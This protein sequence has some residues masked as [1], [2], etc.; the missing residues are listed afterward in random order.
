MRNHFWAV[1]ATLVLVAL[2]SGARAAVQVWNVGGSGAGPYTVSY[3]LLSGNS[4]PAGVAA[5]TGMTLKVYNSGGTLVATRVISDTTKWTSGAHTGTSGVT[6]DGMDDASNN[7][8]QGT[9]YAQLEITGA[10]QAAPAMVGGVTGLAT[11]SGGNTDGRWSF[12][13]GANW[14]IT[15]QYHNTMFWPSTNSS[16]GAGKNGVYTVMPD[17]SNALIGAS[18]TYAGGSD[19]ASSGYSKAACV[20]SDGYVAV[21]DTSSNTGGKLTVLAPNASGTNTIAQNVYATYGSAL[22]TRATAAFGTKGSIDLFYLD[23]AATST[24]FLSGTKNVNYAHYGTGAISPVAIIPSTNFPSSVRSIAVNRAMNVIWV[25]GTNATGTVTTFMVKRFTRGAGAINLATSWT[26]DGA[27]SI[28]IPAPVATNNQ[29]AAWVA[30]S[31]DESILWVS[32]NSATGASQSAVFGVNP[33][34][35]VAIAGQSITGTSLPQWSEAIEPFGAYDGATYTNGNLLFATFSGTTGTSA[36]NWGIISPADTG[37]ADK[38][39]GGPFS[40]LNGS[41]QVNITSGPNVVPNYQG[42]AFSWT[43]DV[44]SDTKVEYGLTAS[45]GAS[46]SDATPNVSHAA[47][48]TG[49]LPS[50]HYFY[51][52]TSHFAAAGVT[53]AV[54]TGTFD[55]TALT[56][57]GPTTTAT[58]NGAT[59][60]WSTSNGPGG[61]AAASTT[62][63]NYGTTS[64]TYFKTVTDN[65]LVSSHSVTLP[66]IL[67][68]TSYFFTVSGG[69]GAGVTSGT[70]AE[71][72][73]AT[74][75]SISVSND[76]LTATGTSATISFNTNLPCTVAMVWGPT[77]SPTTAVTDAGDGTT[78]HSYTVTGLTPGTT[79]YYTTTTSGAGSITRGPSAVSAF[80]TSKA[81][82]PAT[83]TQTTAADVSLSSRVNLAT[84]ADGAIAS[85]AIQGVPGVPIAGTALPSARFYNSV[86]ISRGFIYVLGGRTTSAAASSIV[87]VAYNTIS[88]SGALGATWTEVAANALP[89]GIAAN[90][91]M[92]FAYNGYIYYAGG[93]NTTGASV[94]TVYYTKQNADGTL[95]LPAG[96]TAAGT[97][98]VWTAATALP[99]TRYLGSARTVDGYAMVS[100]GFTT[101]TTAG[102]ASDA[103]Y[104]ARIRP[105][106]SLGSWFVSRATDTKTYQREAVNNHK[107]YITGGQIN[108]GLTT[109]NTE[110]VVSAQPNRDLNPWVRVTSL[111]GHTTNV[112]DNP[113][114][115]G[116]AFDG[117]WSMASDLVR[118]KII[119]AAG[120]LNATTAGATQT[121]TNKISYTK[122]GADEIPGAWTDATAASATV[123]YPVAAIDL[124]AA[125]WNGNLYAAGGRTDAVSAAVANVVQ[126]PFVDEAGSPYCYSGT[127]ESN[128]ID[129]TGGA[130]VTNLKRLQVNGTGI[131]PSS[132]E[133]RYRYCDS[134]GVLTDWLTAASSDEPL[135]G[136]ARY[137]QYQLVLKGN[138]TATPTVSSV[139]VTTGASADLS[140]SNM[141]V[142]NPAPNP[143]ATVTYTIVVANNGPDAAPG[144]V[145]TDNL[146]AT[147]TFV[148]ATG[149]VVGGTGNSRTVTIDN[150]PSGGTA[151]VTVTA[152]V[153]AGTFGQTITN[154]ASESFT[155]TDA[156]A[157]N[158]TANAALTVNSAVTVNTVTFNPSAV[159]VNRTTTITATVTP[160]TNPVATVTADLSPIGGSPTQALSNGGA[161]NTY[162][163]IATVGSGVSGGSKTINVLATDA[164]DGLTGA[165]SGALTVYNATEM[166][167]T[168]EPLG[169][170]KAFPL[171]VQPV[172][173]VEA[174]NGD[175]TTNYSGPVTIALKAGTGTAGAVL[176]GTLTVNAVAG[177]ATFTDLAID[178]PGTGYVLTA[179]AADL[180]LSVDSAAFSVG[181]TPTGPWGD[182]DQDG[183]VTV[184]D[185]DLVDAYI[186][187]PGSLS[188]PQRERIVRYG[189]IAGAHNVNSVG[190]GVVDMNDLLR[191][192]RLAAGII[193]PGTA[194][195]EFPH[196]GDVDNDG[197]VTI[198]D[199]V[200][201]ARYLNGLESDAALIAR[202]QTAGVG[203]VAPT[204]QK[205]AFGDGQITA[206]D[207]LLIRQRA[208]GT[209]VNPPAYQDYW[210]MIP[211]D[212]YQFTDINRRS[213]DALNQTTFLTSAGANPLNYSF[214]PRGYTVSEVVADDGASLA[215]VYKGI[216]GSIYAL[217]AQFPYFSA[218]RMD[219]QSPMKV[220]D[221][222]QLTPGASWTG[223]IVGNMTS[224]GLH[225]V[226][227]K[228]T[229]LRV[230]DTYTNAAGAYNTP[231]TPIFSTW[232]QT[233]SIRIDIAVLASANS[234]IEMQQAVFFDFAPGIGPVRRGQAPIQGMAAPTNDRPLIELDQTTVRSITYSKTLPTP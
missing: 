77:T 124:D 34:T 88:A 208:M 24:T 172:V 42:A 123:V 225:P 201:L 111:Q 108:P 135:S 220:L 139:T 131:T 190:N 128:I 188:L 62:V 95:S 199:L 106:G 157:G 32:A 121:I 4:G 39:R 230:G 227:Y 194:G 12:N 26:L 97:S 192:T 46:V 216:N 202:I 51:R 226:H 204:T 213:G 175:P 228:V 19:S 171:K 145:L 203:D 80:T 104:M 90:G 210:P 174:A 205:V 109:Y 163:Y 25:G 1:L 232:S 73:F 141:T 186:A 231:P 7:L 169:G 3:N 133:I 105:D 65:T 122:L 206:A 180:S 56:I 66:G 13:G 179:T 17:L 119:S 57:T 98:T 143:G 140:I 181:N 10:A 91:N 223:D 151:T 60:T 138:G 87:N 118:G 8:P 162:T 127:F 218:Q 212:K 85:L 183:F 154:T 14:D 137:F 30:L 182:V 29:A 101:G 115:N 15:S 63:L 18:V 158:D 167:F 164:F 184:T 147:L 153:N 142:D 70:S 233:V 47:T 112:H 148:S 209:E 43:T 93:I 83:L 144:V 149:G 110:D 152:T 200:H 103:A 48:L 120:R 156:S 74:V 2:A 129:L 193:D 113:G 67:A 102:N 44:Y 126:I 221:V 96:T 89:T 132:I 45:Y 50:T 71:Q 224:V 92:A 23:E 159:A 214:E 99:N 64:G 170:V 20:L 234:R 31:P 117:H 177:V 40:V 195:P 187:N 185:A 146:P 37:S 84:P 222:T 54:V 35:G 76:R 161:G 49:L 52:V 41:T 116:T 21:T 75:P 58:E 5:I 16:G 166:A 61:S 107:V 125:Q 178:V 36:R 68:N 86:A 78:S 150:I 215:G 69:P 11:V 59:I 38:T 189:D 229:V 81:G 168:T 114:A 196:Y 211:G 82:L 55:T 191:I 22:Y 176:S 217:Y 207:S 165:G 130:T 72:T 28:T 94:N 27:F 53:D 79:Y 6:W 155:G 9:Y 134:G 197:K 136:A 33:T 100:G 160:G 219:F 173:T 198:L